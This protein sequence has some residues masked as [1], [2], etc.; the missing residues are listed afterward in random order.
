M[1]KLLIAAMLIAITCHAQVE[2]DVWVGMMDARWTNK[3]IVY[4]SFQNGTLVPETGGALTGVV[5]R[6]YAV[7]WG[8]G[9]IGKGLV[10]TVND[11][12]AKGTMPSMM[13]GSTEG[14]WAAWV[15]VTN[16]I[17]KANPATICGSVVPSTNQFRISL[18]PTTNGIVPYSQIYNGTGSS[19][20]YET[21]TI[22]YSFDVWR[23]YVTTYSNGDV[24]LF[25][26]GYEIPTTTN[27]VGVGGGIKTVVNSAFIVCGL[28]W[29]Y[30]SIKG[31]VDEVRVYTRAWSAQDVLD[32]WQYSKWL[33]NVR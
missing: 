18:Y 2:D 11:F 22:N 4:H 33:Y 31:S 28:D 9:F 20:R 13:S 5:G 14:T 27:S 1:R 25:V 17:A 30:R 24:R 32:M 19:N 12:Y 29:V 7:N 23:Y 16:T 3:C 6:A 21:G 10:T 26:D 15:M 8:S